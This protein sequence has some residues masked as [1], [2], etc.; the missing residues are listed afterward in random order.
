MQVLTFS[1]VEKDREV[2]TKHLRQT[3]H[4]EKNKNEKD[5]WW[6]EIYERKKKGTTFDL[7]I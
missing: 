6:M 5:W 2:Y 3:R 4:T 1:L 7:C